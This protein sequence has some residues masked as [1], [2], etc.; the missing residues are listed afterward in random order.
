M[1]TLKIWFARCQGQGY[2]AGFRRMFV[3][4]KVSQYGEFVKVSRLTASCAV[5]TGGARRSFSPEWEGDKIEL[6]LVTLWIAE[7][8]GFHRHQRGFSLL[9]TGYQLVVLH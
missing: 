3:S 1:A 2:Q 7:T 4:K 9:V 6:W 5:K 8:G